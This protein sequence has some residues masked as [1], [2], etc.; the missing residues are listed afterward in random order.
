MASFIVRD[1]DLTS[2]AQ[3]APFM[4]LPQQILLVR[5]TYFSLNTPINPH[6]TQR[7]GSLHSLDWN[8]AAR[9]WKSLKEAYEKLGFYVHVVE[10][11]KELPDLVFAANQTLP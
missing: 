11:E 1:S 6:M 10:G 2:P 5:P 4:P 8:R 7:D 9:Q 3:A